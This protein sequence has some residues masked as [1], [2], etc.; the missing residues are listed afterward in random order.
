M[1]SKY[2]EALN[3]IIEA[4]QELEIRVGNNPD[5]VKDFDDIATLQE[6]VD[7]ES[8]YKTLEEELG[9]SLPILFKALKNGIQGYK[10]IESLYYDETNKIWYIECIYKYGDYGMHYTDALALKDYGKTW[11]LKEDLKSE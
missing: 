5:K 7:K 4:Y 9:I 6:L 11:W 3:D 8:K 2:Q 1:L 10:S